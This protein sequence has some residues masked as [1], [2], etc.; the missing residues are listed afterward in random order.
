MDYRNDSLRILAFLSFSTLTACGS[1]QTRQNTNI[2]TNARLDVAQAAEEG[3]NS[4]LAASLY[5]S[6]QSA[7]E[8][9]T[10]Q[11]RIA[12]GLLRTGK[13]SL[14]E[15]TVKQALK[16]SPNQPDLVRAL[17]L[18]YVMDGKP[19]L[20]VPEF[21]QLLAAKPDDTRA[22][23]DKGVALDLLNQHVA[24]QAQYKQALALA[25][26]DAEVRN[27]LALSL[28]M[29]GRLQEAKATLAPVGGSEPS[30]DRLRNNMGVIYAAGGDSS[31]ARRLLGDS[32]SPEALLALTNVITR[33]SP[34]V[35]SSK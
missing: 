11:L 18:V 5:S 31:E 7:P 27:D 26:D 1:F 30:S 33:S 2:D 16:T 15:Q 35:A 29:Q 24:A 21:D 25:P 17:A 4:A 12:D 3:G 9:V 34:P 8:D 6:V 14:A 13:I 22:I 23:V 19:E 10:T 28:M 20:A 32:I